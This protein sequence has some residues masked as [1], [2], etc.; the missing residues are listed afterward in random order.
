MLT[1]SLGEESVITMPIDH[2]QNVQEPYRL[3]EHIYATIARLPVRDR[4]VIRQM[5]GLLPERENDFRGFT[6][7]LDIGSGLGCWAVGVARE[8]PLMEVIGIESHQALVN[9]ASGHADA[10]EVTNTSFA[11]WRGERPHLP[12]ASNHFDLVN[13]HF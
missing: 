1:C 6:R 3:G 10:Q 13:A 12:F 4:M 2:L 5:G 11:L 9:Y 8:N 7:V